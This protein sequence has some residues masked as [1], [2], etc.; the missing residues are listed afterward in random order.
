MVPQRDCDTSVAYGAM[1]DPVISRR[2]RSSDLCVVVGLVVHASGAVREVARRP[3]GTW[4][5][6]GEAA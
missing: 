1:M 2:T 3:R 6:A 4:Q 5:T